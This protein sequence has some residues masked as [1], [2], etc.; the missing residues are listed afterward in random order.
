MRVVWFLSALLVSGTLHAIPNYQPL[1]CTL[2]DTPRD[3]FLFYR[4]QMVYQSEQFL[5]FQNFKGRVSTQVDVKTGELIRT[6]YIGEPFTPKY[7]ILFGHCD[8]VDETLQMWTL[9]EFPYDN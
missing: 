9:N 8:N 1:E 6:T 3:H 4:E 2:I 5:I 7:Q